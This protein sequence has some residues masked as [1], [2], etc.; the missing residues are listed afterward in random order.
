[1]KDPKPEQCPPAPMD[2]DVTG[3]LLPQPQAVDLLLMIC[4]AVLLSWVFF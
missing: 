3:L 2:V 4:G 1:M